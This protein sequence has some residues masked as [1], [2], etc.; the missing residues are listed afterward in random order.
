MLNVVTW[1]KNMRD[2]D[3]NENPSTVQSLNMAQTKERNLKKKKG[4][5]KYRPVP[6]ISVTKGHGR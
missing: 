1:K 6:L 5:Q 4:T 3:T 2:I